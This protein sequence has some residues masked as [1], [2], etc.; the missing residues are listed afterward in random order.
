MKLNIIDSNNGLSP[1][2]HQA[3]NWTNAG[4]TVNWNLYISIQENAFENVI[5]QMAA[6][7][8]RT[9]CVNILIFI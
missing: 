4:I 1:G 2:W 8:S 9:Q 5:C 7:F 6:I 3:I